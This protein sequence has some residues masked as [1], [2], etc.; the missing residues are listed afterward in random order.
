MG[1]VDDA[2]DAEH[3]R[4]PAGDQRVIA[5]EQHALDDL[6]EEDQCGGALLSEDA[7]EAEIGFRDL[8]AAQRAGRPLDRDRAFQHAD[9]A[10]RGRHGALEVL[11]DQQH[12]DAGRFQRLEPGVDAIDDQR[13]KPERHLVEQQEVRV[14]HQRAPDRRRLL[15]AARQCAGERAAALLEVGKGLHHRV[16]RPGAGPPGV[17]REQEVLLDRQAREQPP[18]FGHERQARAR[19]ARGR[20]FA[21]MSSPLKATR[22]GRD[23]VRAGDACAEAW[24][25]RRRSRRR[26][27]PSRPCRWKGSRRARPGAGHGALRAARPKAASNHA[28]AEIGLDHARIGHHALRRAVGDDPPRV[29]ADQAL[30]DVQAGYARYAR[31]RRSRSRALSVPG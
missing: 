11:L 23:P 6:V 1:E 31:S 26:A 14:H 30:G 18:A 16:E 13:R 28:S 4:Q 8:F 9:G 10:A 15:L 17:A 22:A 27:R 7:L 29:H 5:A 25:C 12:R 3:E 2:H 24:S 20:L 21:L 19:R